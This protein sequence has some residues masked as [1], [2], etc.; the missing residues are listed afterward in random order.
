MPTTW[1]WPRPVRL[2]RRWRW[3]RAEIKNVE[4]LRGYRMAVQVCPR[5]CEYREPARRDVIA[6]TRLWGR[7]AMHVTFTFETTNCPECGARLARKCARCD[8][9]I[10]APVV[11]RCQF[12]GLPQPWAAER[13]MGAERSSIRLWRPEGDDVKEA[14]RRVHDPAVPLYTSEGRGSLWV[15]DGDIARLDVDAVV[16]NDDVDGQMW[17]QVARAIKTAAGEGVEPLAQEGKPFRLGHAW[18]TAAGALKMKGII[19]VASMGRHG[20]SSLKTVRECLHASLRV[21]S[22]ESYESI[23]IAAIGS[24]PASIDPAE[25]FRT[26]AEVTTKHLSDDLGPKIAAAPQLAIVLVL[27]EPVD[28]AAEIN[29]LNRAVWDAFVRLGKPKGGEPAVRFKRRWGRL[30]PTPADRLSGE[31]QPA[32]VIKPPADIAEIGLR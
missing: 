29:T 9:D 16:S 22:R 23:G 25:W 13:R 32:D 30:T 18:V 31:D 1:G 17:A 15:I 8:H 26:F 12:C 11:D 19:H 6:R 14:D 21:A 24:G 27:F 28:F 2:W 4:D 10:F 20:E 7:A 5:G 3:R